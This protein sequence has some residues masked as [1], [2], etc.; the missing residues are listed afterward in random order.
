[1]TTRGRQD[2]R[3][4]KDDGKRGRVRKGGYELVRKLALQHRLVILVEG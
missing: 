4:E 1:M 2:D 3:E